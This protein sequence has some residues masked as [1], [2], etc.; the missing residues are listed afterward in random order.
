MKITFKGYGCDGDSFD[1]DSTEEVWLLEGKTVLRT[2]SIATDYD[3]LT[4]KRIIHNWYVCDVNCNHVT[5]SK[6]KE[7]D[8]SRYV[9]LCLDCGYYDT[10]NF[11]RCPE[12]KSISKPVYVEK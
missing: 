11:V 9:A 10:C 4:W 12:C 7:E 6:N 2:H 8:N 1:L 5:F 3:L